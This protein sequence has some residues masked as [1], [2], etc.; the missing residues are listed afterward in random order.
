MFVSASHR[1][2][3]R[4]AAGLMGVLVVRAAVSAFVLLSGFRALSDD[5]FSRVV[6]AQS[7]AQHPSLDPSQT[8]WLPFPFW[9]YGTCLAVFGNSLAHARIIAILVGI[10]SAGGIWLAGRWLGLSRRASLFGAALSCTLP[11]AAYLGVA[12]TPDYLNAVMVVLACSSL[13]RGSS[14]IRALGAVASLIACLSRYESWP[15][16]VLFAAFTAVEAMRHR[17]RRR[18]ALALL[19]L[20]API[21]WMGQ[22]ILRHHDAFFFVKRVASYRRALGVN[23]S[24][25]V[26]H[27]LSTPVHLF[28]DALELWVL[29]IIVVLVSWVRKRRPL[30]ARWLAPALALLGMLAFLIF[31]DWRDGA[32]THHIGRTLLPIWLF[33]S[34]VFA[35]ALFGHK[36]QSTLLTRALATVAIAFAFLSTQIAPRPNK[37]KL[38]GFCP[39]NEETAM[40]LLAAT[41]VPKGQRLAIDTTDYGYFAIQAAFARPEYSIVLDKHDPRYPSPSPGASAIRPALTRAG[42]RWLV[43]PKNKA[44]GVANAKVHWQGPTLALLELD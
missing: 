29:I 28:T 3:R 35:S 38:D 12:T 15:V 14:R 6:I 34:L 20:A 22:G 11:Y 5:D 10:A 7:F 8:S 23:A 9:L 36:R 42:A 30:R 33:L 40:G 16:A 32:P 39:R 41:K 37:L 31:G 25:D 2:T 4:F 43:I 19:V 18:L 13:A 26:L 21:A 17:S 24:T 1:M 27:L 44:P